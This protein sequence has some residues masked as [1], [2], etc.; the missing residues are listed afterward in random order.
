MAAQRQ[1]SFGL[2]SSA[3]K[4]VQRLQ[5]LKERADS[6]RS[7]HRTSSTKKILGHVV[8]DVNDSLRALQAWR[9]ELSK[10]VETTN[11]KNLQSAQELFDDLQNH[12]DAAQDSLDS[13]LRRR[14]LFKRKSFERLLVQALEDVSDTISKLQ[15]ALKVIRVGSAKQVDRESKKRGVISGASSTYHTF[16]ERLNGIALSQ[17]H[18]LRTSALQLLWENRPH[19]KD[20]EGKVGNA[21]DP[22]DGLMYDEERVANA[23]SILEDL[24]TA[25]RDADTLKK[26]P[27]PPKLLDMAKI[28][29]IVSGMQ[30][31][32]L[33]EDFLESDYI[34]NDLPLEKRRLE[35]ALKGQNNHFASAF[36][37]EQYRAVPRMWEE[38]GHL[39][40]DDEEPLPLVH[41]FNYREGSYGTV[42]RVRDSFSGD[43]YA[44]KQQIIAL[45]D[46][47]TVAAEKHLKDETNRL[48]EL[49]HRHIVQLVKSYRRGKA[50]GI[51]LRPAATCDL[52]R[53]LDRFHKDKFCSSE[54]C[55][56]SVWLRPVFLT[57]FGCLSH[58]LAYIHGRKI[59]HKDVKPANILYEKAYKRNAA[60]RFLWADFGLAHDFSET[61][62]S[63]TRS[64]KLYSARYAP[65]EI[66]ATHAKIRNKNKMSN[67][68]TKLEG[69]GENEDEILIAPEVSPQTRE[70]ELDSHGRSADIFSLGCVFLELLARLMK[71]EL[72]LKRKDPDN[73]DEKV[74]FSNNIAGLITWALQTKE[75]DH[76]ADFRTL[77]SLA[78]KM[79][80]TEAEDRPLVDDVV[81]TIV[82]D[83]TLGAKYFCSSCWEEL[84]K[85][86]PPKPVGQS[87]RSTAKYS[88]K[89]SSVRGTAPS[90][91]RS[92]SMAVIERINSLKSRPPLMRIL[93]LS[94]YGGTP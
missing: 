87:R 47:I 15:N 14:T 65:P 55:N 20:L 82:T 35:T 32:G 92:S 4:N 38:G 80:T 12:V 85:D 48:R 72:P 69:I 1:T 68:A 57:A 49:R 21:E 5:Q 90:S 41:K 42:N 25:W 64:T 61:G 89:N 9:K 26:S 58:G 83:Q 37:S 75:L 63:K 16:C 31:Q 46:K 3:D 74:M 6:A 93:S 11:L 76:A 79:I 44:R 53:L 29:L 27:P 43:L 2:G 94:S 62:D 52:Q 24:H 84:P 70:E 81:N 91:P 18:Q 51:I 50:Y 54:G 86:L 59:R 30:R 66:V 88:P 71:E 19:W 77:F 8:H 67:I 33:F 73:E 22:G 10:G 45:E 78:A 13:R 34:D 23:K 28:Y 56:D 60:A 36:F 39:E 17:Q 7:S 40:I